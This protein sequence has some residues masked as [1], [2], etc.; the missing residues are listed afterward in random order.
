MP[1]APRVFEVAYELFL[2]GIHRDGR[3]ALIELRLHTGVDVLELGVAVGV[4]HLKQPLKKWQ[5]ITSSVYTLQICTCSCAFHTRGRLLLE[6][7][8]SARTGG[9]WT[10]GKLSWLLGIGE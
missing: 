6:L 8:A 2:L 7:P 4:H 9:R 3:L 1:F 10:Y 5:A